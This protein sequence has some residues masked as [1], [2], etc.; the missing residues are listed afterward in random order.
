VEK[1]ERIQKILA[2]ADIASRR[3]SEALIAQ[4]RVTVNGKKAVLG[5]KA[6]WDKDDIR[7]DGIPIDKTCERKYLILNKP[8]G[9]ITA[10]FDSHR[11]KTVMDFVPEHIRERFRLFPV[12]RLD[13][14]SGGL[15]LLTNDGFLAN[16]V[17]HPRYGV[18]RE[19]LIEIEPV[20]TPKDV[21]VL[22][23]G[24]DLEEGNTGPAEVSV[25]AVRGRRALVK[26]VIYT[27]RKRQIRR[28]FAQ[29]GYKVYELSRVRIDSIH[30]GSL[31][32]GEIRE[33][34]PEEVKMLYRATG[35]DV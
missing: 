25:V 16:R 8:R 4:G 14:D 27:G 13:M 33:L 20:L 19:Y 11:R 29:L 18:P 1:K 34:T 31:K 12:G 28:S 15:I 23:K 17:T 24:V 6:S 10:T 5:D 32:T 21:S 22:R 30:I 2:R 7:I 35:I 26:M 9:V 3:A